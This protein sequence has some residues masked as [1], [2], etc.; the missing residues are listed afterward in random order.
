MSVCV[1]H[2]EWLYF[3]TVKGGLSFLTMCGDFNSDSG[4]QNDS[5]LE[6][7]AKLTH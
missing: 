2:C 3:A 1:Q 6:Y 5:V 7:D 4:M